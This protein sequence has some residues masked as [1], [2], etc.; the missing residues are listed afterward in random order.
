MEPK[1]ITEAEVEE[2][3]RQVIDPE[4]GC[5]IVDLGLVYGISIEPGKLKISLTL[6]SPG[7]PMTESMR[8]GVQMALLSDFR[9]A[10]AEVELVWSPPWNPD[11]MTEAGKAA[12]GY[13]NF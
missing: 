7:C 3:L 10:E 9:V 4:L 13:C 11:M 6:T 1:Q 8:H 2:I 12:T 5:N